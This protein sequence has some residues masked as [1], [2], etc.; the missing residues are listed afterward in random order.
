MFSFSNVRKF[1]EPFPYVVIDSPLTESNSKNILQNFPSED[2]F[3]KFENVMGGR[4]RLS[5]DDPEFYSFIN[6]SKY[7]SEFYNSINSKEFIDNAIS[8]FKED[9]D[10]Y[11]SAIDIR[12]FQFDSE[13]LKHKAKKKNFMIV[14]ANKTFVGLVS[15][16][17]LLR[18]ILDRIVKKVTEFFL[19]FRP[20]RNK[21][22]LYVHFDISAAHNGYSRE[23]HHDND[24]R[25]IAMVFYLSDHVEDN[26]SGGEFAIH[27]YKENRHLSKCEAHPKEE[28]VIEVK[29]ILPAKN[30]GVIFLSTPNSYHS[31][32][33]I[34]N[35]E[36]WRKFVYIGIT[37]DNRKAWEN[38]LD[39]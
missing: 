39:T 32:P 2:K 10:L 19:R 23:V 6:K 8:L 30:T 27:K 26:R 34:E 18:I 7:W 15:S 24:D 11:N 28:D 20:Q 38:S 29:R 12:G 9:F 35:A 3:R 13:F 25:V 33:F 31:V 14:K 4:R 22:T 17:L 37:V 36:H 5:S 1:T 16:K 21:T